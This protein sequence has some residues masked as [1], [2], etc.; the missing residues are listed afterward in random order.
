MPEYQK[1]GGER[2][3]AGGFGGEG[4]GCG[5]DK[6][7]VNKGRYPANIILECTRDEAIEKDGGKSHTNPDCPCNVLDRQQNNLSASKRER[8]MG[9]EGLGKKLKQVYMTSGDLT[10]ENG[11]T[12]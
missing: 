12:L 6:T 11:E 8:N 4:F 9:L 7:S 2:K 10:N 1:I 3:S 5:G